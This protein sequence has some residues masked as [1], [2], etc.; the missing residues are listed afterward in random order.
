MWPAAVERVAAFARA[1][2]IEARLEQLP[3]GGITPEQRA[4]AIGCRLGQLVTV[5]IYTGPDEQLVV[6]L[7]PGDL[8]PDA[9]A[10]SRLSGVSGLRAADADESEKATGFALEA[11]PPFPLPECVA[12]VERRLL[13]E[14]FVW[15]SAGSVEHALLLSVPDLVRVVRGRVVDLVR[16]SA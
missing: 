8:E 5:R 4:E 15:V 2:G 3:V 10:V 13:A 11:V 1:A 14:P 9:V 12:L 16:E 6:V 7:A